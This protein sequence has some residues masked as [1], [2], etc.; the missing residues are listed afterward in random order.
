MTVH[1]SYSGCDP[2]ERIEGIAAPLKNSSVSI[3]AL[4]AH[5]QLHSIQLKPLNL[6]LQN[7]NQV[8]GLFGTV[9]N[10]CIISV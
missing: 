6:L 1:A 7:G 5:V 8:A 2:P 9:A 4:H 10:E 3:A